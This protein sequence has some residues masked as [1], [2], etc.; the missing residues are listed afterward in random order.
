M[1]ILFYFNF[2]YFEALFLR[3]DLLV[4][5]RRAGGAEHQGD[6][7]PGQLCVRDPAQ[8]GGA[9]EPPRR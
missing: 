6:G 5:H 9:P 1:F 2:G 3:A 7:H 4:G 8:P